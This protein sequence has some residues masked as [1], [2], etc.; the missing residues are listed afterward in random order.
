MFSLYDASVPVY[1]RRL[2]AL[3]AILAKAADY[4]AKREIE[5]EALLGDRLYPD[6][7][8]LLTQVQEACS[9]ARRGTARLSAVD[10]VKVENTEKSFDDLRALIDRTVATLKQVDRKAIEGGEARTVTFPSGGGK[11]SMSAADYLLHFSMPNF[12]FHLTTAYA[13]LR[14]NGLEVGKGDFMGGGG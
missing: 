1:V 2:T 10:P 7:Y 8:P 12:Y 4:A 5:P 14:H 9:H 3:S 6:M 13:I 11:T